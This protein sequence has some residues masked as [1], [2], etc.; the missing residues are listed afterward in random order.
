MLPDSIFQQLETL[1]PSIRSVE[2]VHGGD[3]N[4]AALIRTSSEVYFIK[5]NSGPKAAAMLSTE[6]TGLQAIAASKSIA[7]PS[8]LH[9]STKPPYPFL[10]LEYIPNRPGSVKEKSIFGLQLAQMHQTSHHQFGWQ[11][12]NFIGS[13]PQINTWQ[14]LASDYLILNRLQP[15]FSMAAPFFSSAYAKAFE[16]LCIEIQ[17]NWPEEKARLIHGDL[18]GGNYLISNEGE[19]YLIDPSVSYGLR[20]MD[21]A[22]SQ[23]F[24]NFGPS[25]YSAYQEANPMQVDWKSRIPI[26]QLYYLLVHVNLFGGAYVTSVKNILNPFQK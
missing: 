2:A 11:E 12:N 9:L 8:I 13:L 22:M 15:Q 7:T 19:P 10:L 21:I 6:K 17:Q 1:L 16:H 23:L 3:I 4:Q 5:Y 24:G 20:E 26:Y 25:F 14:N 18:W